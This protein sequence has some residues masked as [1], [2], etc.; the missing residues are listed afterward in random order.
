MDLRKTARLINPMD[1][2][3]DF[4]KSVS[5]DS[6]ELTPKS[7]RLFKASVIAVCGWALIEAPLELGG[8][9]NST[10]LLA[11]VASKILIG[12]IG[13][14]AIVNLRF[15]RQVFMFICGASVFAI[16]PALPLEYTHSVPVA[17]FSTVECLGKAACVAS[18]VIASLA[19]E[20][21][22]EHLSVGNRKGVDR[23]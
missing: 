10:S 17:L 8:S 23:T 2:E 6:L 16:A 19:R 12:L 9:I 7:E 20:S 5:S 15:A 13:T 4:S 21:V 3:E 14:A 11:L 22:G 18:F 1:Y